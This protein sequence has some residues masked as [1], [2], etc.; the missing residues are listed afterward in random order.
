MI[1][2][3]AAVSIRF[4]LPFFSA[5]SLVTYAG[6]RFDFILSADQPKNLYWIRFRGLM[7]CDERFTKAHQVAL[8]E[9]K[10]YAD[11]D[12]K[13][14][15]YSFFIFCLLFLII[16]I[17]LKEILQNYQSLG[18]TANQISENGTDVSND[19]PVTLHLGVGRVNI[20]SANVFSD[21]NEEILPDGNPDYDNSHREGKVKN[22][23]IN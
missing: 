10:G 14:G 23:L 15:R 8:L 19:V 16:L 20:D 22:V 7:D 21:M 3:N 6:E 2:F 9:Y 11:D 13:E 1:I 17:L 4:R 18:T 12:A 5:D